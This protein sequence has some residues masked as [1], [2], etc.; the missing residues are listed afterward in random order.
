MGRGLTLVSADKILS[1]KEPERL[2]SDSLTLSKLEYRDLAKVW[3]P[4]VNSAP[5][6]QEVMAHISWLYYKAIDKL[7]DKTWDEPGVK[8]EEEQPGIKAFK[9]DKGFVRL[10]DYRTVREFELGNTYIGDHHVT[11]MIRREYEDLYKNGLKRM[12]GYRFANPAMRNEMMRFLPQVQDEFATKTLLGVTIRKTPDCLL[13]RD[14]LEHM[15]G[16]VNPIG[17]IG[18]VLNVL[19]NISCWFQYARLCH[20]DLSLDTYYVSPHHHSG[21]V[22]GGWWYTVPRKQRLLA[23]PHRSIEVCPPD[24]L[25]DK[26]AGF[27]LD[28]ECIRLMGREL[29]GETSGPV[30]KNNPDI[31]KPLSTYLSLPSKGSA[32]D[33]YKHYRHTVLEACWPRKYIH[34]DLKPEDLYSGATIK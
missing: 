4:D 3:H 7:C 30:L 31:P 32:V 21:M 11:Y 8:I 22:L 1:V 10:I 20:N 29:L 19:Y 5:K 25:R 27:R 12:Q 9:T 14:V 17:H 13:L 24:L 15:G 26:L 28:Q 16:T 23:L 33:D 6:A 2:F 34:L 18:W